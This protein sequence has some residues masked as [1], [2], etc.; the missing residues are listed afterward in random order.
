MSKIASVAF[1]WSNTNQYESGSID[2]IAH[3][4]MRRKP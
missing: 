2:R 1:I 4:E 3:E